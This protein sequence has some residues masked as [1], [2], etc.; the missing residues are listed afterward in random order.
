LYYVVDEVFYLINSNP[1]ILDYRDM[2]Y[3]YGGANSM[4]VDLDINI[5]N[6]TG[7]NAIKYRWF[8]GPGYTCDEIS[9]F[10]PNEV[11]SIL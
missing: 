7:L 6:T 3:S 5:Y 9:L 1:I 2:N 8:G 10:D 4:A 11:T